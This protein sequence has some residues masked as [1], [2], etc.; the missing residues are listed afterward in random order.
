[1]LQ[2]KLG[3]DQELNVSDFLEKEDQRKSLDLFTSTWKDMTKTD[4]ST[5][6][7]VKAFVNIEELLSKVISSTHHQ[8]FI[9][10]HFICW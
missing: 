6:E 7:K 9:S 5:V 8:Q 1:M 3:L 4:E 10:F 2:P